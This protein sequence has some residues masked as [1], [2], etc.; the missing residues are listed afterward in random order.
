M[1]SFDVCLYDK[2]NNR[3]LMCTNPEHPWPAWDGS[4]GYDYNSLIKRLKISKESI[5]DS[6]TIYLTGGEPTLHP[7]FIEL[8]LFLNKNHPKQIIKLLTNGRK[9][10]YL[11]FAK[12]LLSISNNLEIELSLYGPNNIIHDKVTRAPGSFLQTISGLSNLLKLRKKG[13]KINLRFVI[14]KYSY[15]YIKEVIKLVSKNFQQIDN[16]IIIFPEYEAQAIKNINS[17]KVNYDIV[18]KELVKCFS[19]I[20]IYKKVRLYHFPLCVLSEKFWPYIWRTQ[21][22]NEMAFPKNCELCKYKKYCAGIHKGYLENFGYNI[23][24]PIKKKIIL[25]LSDDINHPIIT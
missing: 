14:T 5:N 10:S 25:K 20:N 6:E 22:N 21:P 18:S 17:I 16:L 8:I 3:C 2:C 13:Q 15:R 7:K 24:S 4:F 11:D 19:L 23:F 9:F 1:K 12:N